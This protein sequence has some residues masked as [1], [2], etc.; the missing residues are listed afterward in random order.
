[1]LVWSPWTTSTRTAEHR[2]VHARPQVLRYP[3]RELGGPEEPHLSLSQRGPCTGTWPRCSPSTP[4]AAGGPARC[5]EGS[6]DPR[7]CR[8]VEHPLELCIGRQPAQPLGRDVHPVAIRSERSA[9]SSS[10]G[11]GGAPGQASRAARTAAPHA[12]R[13]TGG[14]PS[15]TRAGRRTTLRRTGTDPWAAPPAGA[16]GSAPPSPPPW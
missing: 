15:R 13:P 6:L 8:L 2:P 7:P 14:G 16:R 3:R 11:V 12:P 9:A 10:N 5:R 4:G 1:M